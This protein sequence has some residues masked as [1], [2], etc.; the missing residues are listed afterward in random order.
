MGDRYYILGNKER[1]AMKSLE[2][3]GAL[4]EKKVENIFPY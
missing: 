1:V 2:S 4:V 3:M